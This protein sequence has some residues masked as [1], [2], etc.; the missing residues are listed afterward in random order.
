MSDFS[1]FVEH[2]TQRIHLSDIIKEDVKLIRK[3]THKYGGL[4][5]FHKEK[6]PS[7]SVSDDKNLYHCFGCGAGG[8]VFNYLEQKRG[9]RFIEA[10]HYLAERVGVTVPKN[11]QYTQTQQQKDDTQND[12]AILEDACLWMQHNLSQ[13]MGE[14][15]R[16]YLKA[17]GISKHMQEKFRLGF[18]P[19][20]YD[21]LITHLQKKYPLERLINVG[22]VSAGQDGRKPIDR[23]R[24]RLMFPIFDRNHRIIAFGGRTITQEQPKYI[25]SSDTP[26]FS[27]SH[28]LYGYNFAC[29]SLN[30][31]K[32]YIVAEGYLDV[33]SLHQ[34][35][36]D[37]A[38]APLGTA[39]TES[40][41]Q[42]LWRHKVPPTLCFDGDQAGYNAAV[43]TAKKVISAASPD[44]RLNFCFLPSG[45]DPDSIVQNNPQDFKEIIEKTM[46]QSQVL[47]QALS[48]EFPV[49]TPE[50]QAK[51]RNEIT[52]LVEQIQHEETRQSYK[53]Y[54][55]QE[56][57]ALTRYRPQHTKQQLNKNNA[58]VLMPPRRPQKKT[59]NSVHIQK[60]LLAT[61]IHHPYL[62]EQEVD[63]LLTINFQNDLGILRDWMITYSGTKDKTSLLQAAQHAGLD[64]TVRQILHPEIINMAPFILQND[65]NDILLGWKEVYNGL[66]YLVK[67]DEDIHHAALK[68]KENM[69]TENWQRMQR[70]Q[71]QALATKIT[72]GITDN[73]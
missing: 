35:G 54:F 59:H 46:P 26:L 57:Y 36:F 50:D 18:T 65:M 15:A 24:N 28:V 55:D 2:L 25:N 27:K 3:S 6:S 19:P 33:I 71:S 66:E 17:R 49:K 61:L 58:G 40:H 53:Q 13:S 45:S 70:L 60:I 8:N 30:H 51:L 9:L 5:P 67:L 34:H 73:D 68:L 38:V 44:H 64:E 69:N 63:T 20:N 10:V 29:K 7:F 42:L 31:Q 62:I 1:K 52:T 16:D 37:T 72:R 39:L 11:T 56:F 41:C 12:Y 43:R 32:G 48:A 22:L 4:C 21:A 14:P 23:F 47:W